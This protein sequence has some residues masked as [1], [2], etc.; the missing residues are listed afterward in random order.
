[1]DRRIRCILFDIGYTL[2]ERIIPDTALASEALDQ[3]LLFLQEYI[4]PQ[5]FQQ[6]DQDKVRRELLPALLTELKREEKKDPNYEPDFGQV[7]ATVLTQF[8]L[9]AIEARAGRRLFSS[10]QVSAAATRRLFPGALETLQALQ[11]RGYMLGV[12]TN[13]SW[14]GPSFLADLQQLGLLNFFPINAIAISADLGIR[15][16]HAAIFHYALNALHASPVEAAMVGDSLYADVGG[17]Q[18]LGIATVWKPVPQLYSSLR[19][20][21]GLPASEPVAPTA[22]FAAGLEYEQQ[23]RR[24]Q[25]N[26]APPDHTIE[27][28]HDLLTI[29]T[30]ADIQ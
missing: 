26:V 3:A 10:L 23:R 19:E 24:R 11:Q 2:W 16:P 28:L 29:F 14:G 20:H 5:L 1:M 17:A 21:N 12:V 9:P 30:G 15:K 7:T 27:Q 18:S 22:L 4:N 8:G 6:L 13:R 25:L